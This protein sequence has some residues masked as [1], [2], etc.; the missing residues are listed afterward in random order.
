MQID[1]GGQERGLRSGTLNVPAIVGLGRALTMA[2]NGLESEMRHLKIMREHLFARLTD[3]LD[4]V[5]LVGHPT[6]RVP[7]TLNISFD[8]IEA[9][10]LMNAL[11]ELAV[12]AGSA[13]S[14]AAR[15]TSHVLSAMGFDDEQ[16]RSCIR[17]SI[18]RFNTIEEIERAASL[19]IQAVQYLRN[20]LGVPAVLK[21]QRVASP[22]AAL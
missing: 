9:E 5:T 11:P 4:G 18:G 12:S 14:A 8:L 20:I 10:A 15:K 7:G 13:C 22:A 17:F 6:F 21:T 19:V 16:A 1:G 2:R 3:G